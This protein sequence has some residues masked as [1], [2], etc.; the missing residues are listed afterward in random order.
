MACPQTIAGAQELST[1]LVPES[2]G[3][4]SSLHSYDSLW[5]SNPETSAV[6]S[7]DPTSV[8]PRPERVRLAEDNG[9]LAKGGY[10]GWMRALVR[11]S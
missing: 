6:A 2:M 5:V 10:E 9:S 8:Q 1:A 7:I 11:H 4:T 3:A